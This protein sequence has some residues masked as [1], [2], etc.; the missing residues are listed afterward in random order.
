MDESIHLNLITPFETLSKDDKPVKN[1]IGFN[2]DGA[3]TLDSKKKEPNAELI[4]ELQYND[5]CV[6]F[7]IGVSTNMTIVKNWI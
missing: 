7:T 3:F 5:Y 1:V 4:K 6:D 2:E